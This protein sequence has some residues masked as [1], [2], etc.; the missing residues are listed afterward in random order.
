[1]E[2]F[3]ILRD[4]HLLLLGRLTPAQKARVGVH[5]ERGEESVEHLVRLYAGHDILHLNQIE[6][7]RK[8][9]RG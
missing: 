5:A 2:R 8:A 6:R 4:S 3:A 7:I 9:V 1:M